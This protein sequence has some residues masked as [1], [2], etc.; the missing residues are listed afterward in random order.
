MNFELINKLMHEY[1][2]MVKFLRKNY[3]DKIVDNEKRIYLD[4]EIFEDLLSKKDFLSV[5][6]KKKFWRDLGWI[7]CDK[8][9]ARYTKKLWINGKSS[10]KIVIEITPYLAIEELI[11]K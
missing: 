4:R 2:L 5:I 10:R 6:E 11:N 9:N 1:V 8:D 3:S 7:S